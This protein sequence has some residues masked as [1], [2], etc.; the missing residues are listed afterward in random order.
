MT[1]SEIEKI[2][3]DLT[4][5]HQNLTVEL[6]TTLLL[7]ANWEEKYVKDA[8]ILFKQNKKTPVPQSV[9]LPEVAFVDDKKESVVSSKKEELTFYQQDGTEEGELH[10]YEEVPHSRKDIQEEVLKKGA[11]VFLEKETP[12]KEVDKED[13]KEPE[14]DTINT[15]EEKDEIIRHG[16]VLEENTQKENSSLDTKEEVENPLVVVSGGQVNNNSLEGI[17]GKSLQ[18]ES[19]I[20]QTQNSS[21]IVKKEQE[22]PADLPLLPFESSSHVWSFSRYKEMF[23]EKDEPHPVESEIVKKDEIHIQEIPSV[24]AVPEAEVVKEEVDLEPTPM[25][26]GDESLVFLAGVM[27]LVI[28]LILGYMYSRGRL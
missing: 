14:V 23:H 4:I 15:L 3:D 2:L 22:I 20:V 5:R 19:L 1:L 25:T 16:S 12:E 9:S 6:L 18:P 10:T 26:K 21:K 13:A 8:L 17:A 24:K 28:I 27:L 11:D 7:S